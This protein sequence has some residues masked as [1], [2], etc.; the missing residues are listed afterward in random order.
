MNYILRILISSFL[1]GVVSF[2]DRFA[3]MVVNGNV[4]NKWQ[5]YKALLVTFALM[6]NDIKSRITPTQ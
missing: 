5:I 1:V 4:P 3:E 6:A 2:S